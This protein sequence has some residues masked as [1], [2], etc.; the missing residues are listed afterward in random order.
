VLRGFWRLLLTLMAC[1]FSGCTPVVE[2][3]PED[4]SNP[5]L[6]SA[7]RMLEVHDYKG[8]MEAY[9]KA[10]ERNPR[11]VQVHYELG[12]LYEQFSN[13]READY[14]AAMYHFHQVIRLRPNEYPADNARQRIAA[15][16]RELVKAESLAPVAHQ[17]MTQLEK[18]R[19]ENRKLQLQL[20]TARNQLAQRAA[21]PPVLT[22]AP[23]VVAQAPPRPPPANDTRN[24]R[25][26]PLSS[27]GY[28]TP[29]PAPAPV[30]KRTHVIRKGET[31][32]S[33]SRLYRV[34]IKD[35]Q[36]ANPQLSP[37]RIKPGQVVYLP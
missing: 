4:V 21:A 26:S 8:A 30:R 36:R 32:S 23:P 33:I 22:S 9:E 19:E 29:L 24:P 31:L 6:A 18:L 35:L 34:H 2:S 7:K 16:K 15:C 1:A 17:L 25:R 5:Y 20:D 3:Q 10:L 12:L 13:Q 27:P 28:V 14:I 11:L 37:S